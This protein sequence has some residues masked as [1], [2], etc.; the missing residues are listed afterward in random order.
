M[1]FTFLDKCFKAIT[2]QTWYTANEVLGL[3]AMKA[4]QIDPS[5]LRTDSTVVET[6]IHYPTDA[7]LLWDCWRVGTRYLQ[8]LRDEGVHI[9]RCKLSDAGVKKALLY[10]NRYQGSSAESRRQSV[11]EAFEELI[12]AVSAVVEVARRVCAK[13]RKIRG[14]VAEGYAKGLRHYLP[15]MRKVLSVAKRVVLKGQRVPASERVFSIFEEHTELIK[16]GKKH[17]PVE[18]GHAIWLA[19]SPEKFITDYEVMEQKEPDSELLEQIISRHE[20]RYG[21][22]PEVVAADG[23]FRAEKE[24]MAELEERVGELAVPPRSP[25]WQDLVDKVWHHFR[26]GIEGTISGLKRAF[27]LSVCMYRSFQSFEAWVGMAVFCHNLLTLIPKQGK[28]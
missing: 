21:D 11:R 6:N 9:G 20:S 24:T 22:A 26:A 7:S 18:F 14:P 19:Q 13:R 23:G 17:K 2:P 28:T 3:R 5:V 15:L 12:A 10:I 25:R 1:D 27:R 16:R 4:E 8:G